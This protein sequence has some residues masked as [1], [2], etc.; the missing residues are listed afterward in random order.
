MSKK[1]YKGF[2][3]DMTCRGFQFEESKTYEEPEAKLCE[4]GFHACENPLD[5]WK[6]YDVMD[7][8]FHEVE[9][10]GVSEERHSNDTKVCAKK[11]TVGARLDMNGLVKASVD[12][13]LESVKGCFDKKLF[14]KKIVDSGND[15][16]IGSSGYG[17][18]IGS[19]GYGAQIGS[20]GNYAK[21]GSSGYGAQ[22]GSSG[23]AAQIGSPGDGAQIGSS[24]DGAKIGSSGNGAK[25]GS[26]GNGAKIGSS[27]NDA[28]IGSSGNGAKIGSSG[29]DAQIGS[30]GY[31]A[32]IGSSGDAAQIGS[33]GNYAK[34]GS[35]GNYARI[36]IAGERSIGACVGN[37]GKIKAKVGCWIVL[38]EWK[39]VKD[40]YTP[41]CVKSVQVDGEKVKADTWY[42]LKDG[43]L[44]EVQE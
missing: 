29:N 36:D 10:D 42:T 1:Y 39:M 19:S 12:V 41:V 8:V 31:G 20:S 34:I 33:S 6:Y 16:Q 43:E 13:V 30:S 24:G 37:S 2:N 14:D 26:S 23:D 27:G 3:K 21:I 25:I 28:K 15:A 35:S 5:C 18:Q 7:S 22:I 40:K 9:L 44:V 11:I 17:A 4:K 32:Q 38:S